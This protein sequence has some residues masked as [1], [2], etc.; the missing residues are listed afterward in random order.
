MK[1]Q[2]NQQKMWKYNL[3]SYLQTGKMG[4][5]SAYGL[6]LP[7]SCEGREENGEERKPI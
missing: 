7:K 4:V 6:K 1:T 2:P 5:Q 3:F